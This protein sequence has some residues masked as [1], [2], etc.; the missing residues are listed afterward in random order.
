MDLERR[1]KVKKD[2]VLP[3]DTACAKYSTEPHPLLGLDRSA[4]PPEASDLVFQRAKE[5]FSASISNGTQTVYACTARHVLEA[6]KRLGRKFASPPTKQD[7]LYFLTFLQAGMQKM[8][9][10]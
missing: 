9:N 8:F 3:R 10:I 1:R 2:I 5:K 4:L 7:Q 6:E